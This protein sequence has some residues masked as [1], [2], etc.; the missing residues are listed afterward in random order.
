M[1]IPT[2]RRGETGRGPTAQ[3]AG[4]PVSVL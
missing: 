2:P 1:T 3:F 4:G